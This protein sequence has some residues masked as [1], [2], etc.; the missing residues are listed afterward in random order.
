[1]KRRNTI[2]ATLAAALIATPFLQPAPA[3]ADADYGAIASEKGNDHAV[4]HAVRYD[5]KDAAVR[6]AIAECNKYTD[7][8]N[9]CTLR[10][11][12]HKENCAAYVANDE[13]I[14]YYFGRTKAEVVRKAHEGFP[15]GTIVDTACN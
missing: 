13:K 4:A 14:D 7:G 3:S 15:E 1:M 8:K 6:A 5:S 12:F 11:W 10:V 9:D 2:L